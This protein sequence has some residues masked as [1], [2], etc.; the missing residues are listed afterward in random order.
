MRLPKLSLWKGATVASLTS[1]SKRWA[2]EAALADR[3][4]HRG[5]SGGGVRGPL[6]GGALTRKAKGAGM[7]VRRH[8]RRACSM[9]AHGINGSSGAR[10]NDRLSLQCFVYVFS[11][12]MFCITY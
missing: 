5:S 10:T 11:T 7:A 6:G 1:G 9:G 12:C 8:R 4:S 2:A 3:T